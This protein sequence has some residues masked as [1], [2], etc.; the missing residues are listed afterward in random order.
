MDYRDDDIRD[1]GYCPNC[2]RPLKGVTIEGKAYCPRDATWVFVNWNPPPR[3]E[4]HE[5]GSKNQFS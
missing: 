1:A 4:E 5:D 2:G 3:K